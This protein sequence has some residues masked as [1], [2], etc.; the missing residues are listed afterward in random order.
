MIKCVGFTLALL[1]ALIV[2]VEWSFTHF[3]AWPDWI[4]TA[5]Q[6][7]G[8]LA[9]VAASIFLIPPVTSLIA[10]LYL[11]DIAGQVERSAFPSDP[12]GR[13][14]PTAKSIWLAIKFF[15]V[16]LAVNLLALFL[17]LI[18]GVNLVA[19]YVGNGY[20]LGR[21]YFEL[22]AMRHVSAAEAK[23]LRKSNRLTVLLCGLLIAGLASVPILNLVT[24]LFATGFM[25]R[26][27]KRMAVRGG[28]SSRVVG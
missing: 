17:L 21:E 13:E 12:P 2:A 1:A 14:L 24:P 6:W 15:T 26:M 7:L 3:V 16:V 28:F 11:D 5:I 10:G 19:F 8:G 22:A 23:R 9:L 27:Y 4:E 20:L 25:V 18:P